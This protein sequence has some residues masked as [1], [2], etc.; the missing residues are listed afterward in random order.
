MTPYQ[1]IGALPG[2]ALDT[3]MF[4]GWVSI[5]TR[6][7]PRAHFSLYGHSI[8]ANT[9]ESCIVSALVLFP[10]SYC[11]WT[12]IGA[13][14]DQVAVC[15]FPFTLRISL[16]APPLLD[17]MLWYWFPWRYFCLL[18]SRRSC[19]SNP[20]HCPEHFPVSVTISTTASNYKY[21]NRT[22]KSNS[23]DGFQYSILVWALSAHHFSPLKPSA[24]WPSPA[25]TLD[26]D[27]EVQYIHT[28]A[29]E[30]PQVP[31]H[32]SLWR[33]RV[34]VRPRAGLFDIAAHPGLPVRVTYGCQ[35]GR[36]RICPLLLPNVPTHYS[37]LWTVALVFH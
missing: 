37:R 10:L 5:A 22:V 33:R 17:Q 3:D 32:P 23:C 14:Q 18:C 1:C 25:R 4:R 35:P 9:V 12:P 15:L 36:V 13:G 28:Y 34:P 31:T 16:P 11:T 24:C 30:C 8:C 26:N 29:V 6:A 21:P 20:P 19:N 27:D 7:N 2:L